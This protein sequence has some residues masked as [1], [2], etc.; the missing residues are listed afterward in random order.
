MKSYMIQ[1]QECV[2]NGTNFEVK[3]VHCSKLNSI[4]SKYKDYC[5]SSLCR[6]ERMTDAEKAEFYSEQQKGNQ[7]NKAFD[8]KVDKILNNKSKYPICSGA[9]LFIQEAKRIAGKTFKQRKKSKYCEYGNSPCILK[10]T[11]KCAFCK[12]PIRPGVYY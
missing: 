10:D 11:G 5:R 2:K 1:L 8:K 9:P 3:C 12:K 4:C 7:K 6:D